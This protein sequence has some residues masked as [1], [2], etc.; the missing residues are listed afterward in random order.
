[1]RSLARTLA[2]AALLAGAA[3]RAETWEYTL[4]VPEGMPATFEVPFTVAHAGDVV[5]LAE[6]K[7]P[8]LLFF[9]VD[10][11][12]RAG[13][14]RRSGPSPQRI[15]LKA[16][17]DALVG[18]TGWKLTVKALAARGEASG[19]LKITVPDAP[20]VVARREA[21]LH[22]P[23]PP[24]PPPPAWTLPA[25]APQGASI[26]VARVFGA[27]ESYRAAVLSA[28]NPPQDDC[29]W[30][31]EFL[32]YATAVRDRLA[33]GG[34][35]PDVPA[36]RYF[37]RMSEAIAGVERMRTS[38]D[39][40]LA[41]P[42]PEDLYERRLWLTSRYEQVR[43]VER[44]LDQLGELLRGG[45]APSLKETVWLPRLNACITAC[46]RFFDE[47]VRLGSAELASGRE[48]ARSEWPKIQAA[49]AVFQSLAPYLRE[50]S[51]EL[52]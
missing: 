12:G 39:P 14:A 52:R 24:P 26:Q 32:L 29:Q 21:E 31:I 13:F 3:A 44:S 7:G 47:R 48:V 16:D 28:G 6:W 41:G 4:A 1:M 35:P 15:E 9:G 34:Q 2:V 46:E 50:T 33:A 51:A 18:T 37:G 27:V 25:K 45:H 40:I 30:Q 49:A 11:P 20:E 38:K 43:P 8:R 42:V 10:A 17:T 23:P 36:L 22:P 19:T 5:L